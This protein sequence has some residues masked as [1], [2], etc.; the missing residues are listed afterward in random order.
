[1]DVGEPEYGFLERSVFMINA[2]LTELIEFS[3]FHAIF[4]LSQ[5]NE[6]QAFGGWIDDSGDIVPA[7]ARVGGKGRPNAKEID[8]LTQ[9]FLELAATQQ[10]RAMCLCRE[11]SLKKPGGG[12]PTR[13][14]SCIL[15]DSSGCSLELTMPFKFDY[16]SNSFIFGPIDGKKRRPQFFPNMKESVSYSWQ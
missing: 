14:I 16:D 15:E 5:S 7:V 11:V 9:K 12:E 1:M 3:F 10:I 2:V 13:L 4:K 8:T 6:F